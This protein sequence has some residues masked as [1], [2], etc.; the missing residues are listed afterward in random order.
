M[1]RSNILVKVVHVHHYFPEQN[2]GLI[3]NNLPRSEL[4]NLVHVWRQIVQFYPDKQNMHLC[5]WM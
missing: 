4:G 1:I 3:I 5:M 2:K